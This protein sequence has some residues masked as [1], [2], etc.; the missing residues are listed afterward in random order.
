VLDVPTTDQ[1]SQLL[2]EA[3]VGAFV[4]AV[5]AAEPADRAAARAAAAVALDEA[6]FSSDQAKFERDL[7][8]LDDAEAHVRLRRVGPELTAFGKQSFLHRA[9]GV[10]A[11]SGTPATRDALVQIGCDLRMAAPH[12]NGVLAVVDLAA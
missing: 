1:L 3:T 5:R 11:V 10:G 6:G 8:D 7:R 9:A 4:I 2:R 12:I